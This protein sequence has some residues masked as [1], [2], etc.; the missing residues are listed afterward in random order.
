MS[1]SGDVGPPYLEDPALAGALPEAVLAYVKRERLFASGDR[2][3]VAVSGGPD[4]VALLHLLVRLRAVLALELGVAHYDHGLR[5]EDSRRDAEFVADLAQRLGLACHLGRGNVK[6]AARRYKVSIQ[7]A[8]RRLRQQFFLEIRNGYAYTK[9]ALGHTADDQV[10]LFWLRLL[11]GAG[12]EGLKG[13]EPATPQGL[14]RPLLAVG[15]AVLLAWLGQENLPYRLDTSNLSRAYLRNR[16]RLDLL[17]LLT[18]IYNPRLAQTIWR[19]QALL[20][21][22]DRLLRR[23]TASVWDRVARKLGE[24]CYVLDLKKFFGLDESI[25]HRVLRFG[26]H[27]ISSDFALSHAQV[28]GLMV[29]AQSGRSGGQIALGEG[30]LV[31]RAGTTLHILKPLP[32]PLREVTRLPDCPGEVESPEGWRWRLRHRSF[33]PGDP[34]PPPG[35]A[36][37]NP[38]QVSPPLE[39]RARRPGDRFWPQGAPGPKK[40]QDFLVNAKI[41]RWLR[42]HLPLVSCGGEIVWVP[43]LRL[44]EPV[45]LRSSSQDILEIAVKPANNDTARIW[46][47]LGRLQGD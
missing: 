42:P 33:R 28:D 19:T 46:E 25:Q 8:A 22:D 12:L 38:D 35:V 3:L 29:L 6:E 41:P 43:G 31:A 11:R 9:Q 15:K 36:W 4:S 37:L 34:W 32:E 14:V 40:L 26:V 10:E 45:K 17:P 24:D 27:T 13:M 23:D 18:Q 44:A 5:G 16:V 39:V 20:R 47:I 30:V 2:V 1:L 21:E 7:M